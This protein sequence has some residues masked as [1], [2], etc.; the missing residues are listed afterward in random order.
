[1]NTAPLVFEDLHLPGLQKDL[2][3]LELQAHRVTSVIGDG[4]SGVGSLGPIALG[5]ES[6]LR[7]RARIF[8][9]D[10]SEMPRRDVL[11]FRRR[12]GY[13]P[14]GDGLLQNLSLANNIALPLRFGSDLSDSEIDGRVRLMLS[15]FKLVDLGSMRPAQ[16]NDEQRRR[17]ALA[18]ALA[19]D[20]PLVILDQ[21]FDS[22]APKAGAE[23]LELARGG[24]S[25]EGS[26][27][28][29]LITG[30]YLPERLRVR[31]DHRIRIAKGEITS[32]D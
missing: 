28:T 4:A 22:I 3:N 32:D 14:A 10:L 31:F 25:S 17:T 24:V 21:L 13:L 30:Q 15:M 8:G 20:P 27:R 6:P 9:E 12:V 26:R 2:F 11:A 29:L 23:L 1:M 19:F 18:R 16:A 7:G 5:L